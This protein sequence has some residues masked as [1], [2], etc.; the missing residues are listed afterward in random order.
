MPYAKIID[1][2]FVAASPLMAVKKGTDDGWGL[3]VTGAPSHRSRKTVT[4]IL[5]GT[6]AEPRPYSAE[7]PG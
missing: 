7:I 1:K 2:P 5:A 6:A 4:S 3:H